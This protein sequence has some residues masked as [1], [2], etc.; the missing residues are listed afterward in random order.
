MRGVVVGGGSLLQPHRQANKA[1]RNGFIWPLAGSTGISEMHLIPRVIR[2][3]PF[4]IKN[5]VMLAV[6]LSSLQ[7]TRAQ[8]VWARYE[9]IDLAFLVVWYNCQT[10]SDT[11]E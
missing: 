7:N 3:F 5:S 10:C 1:T 2:G 6:T 4:R 11:E 9:I 8:G